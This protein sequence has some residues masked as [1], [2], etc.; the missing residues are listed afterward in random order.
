LAI[1]PSFTNPERTDNMT[2]DLLQLARFARDMALTAPEEVL[3]RQA[4]FNSYMDLHSKVSAAFSHLAPDVPA[5]DKLEQIRARHEAAKQALDDD[6][7]YSSPNGYPPPYFPSRGGEQAHTDRATLLRLLDAARA[8]AA[9]LQAVFDMQRAAQMR[10]IKRWQDATGKDMT[11]PDTTDLCFWLAGQLDAARAELAGVKEAL[12][13]FADY[14]SEWDDP[15]G[16]YGEGWADDELAYDPIVRIEI[17][18]FRRARAA[19]AKDAP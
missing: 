15:E 1:H 6:R 8:N 19:L 18:A 14:A 16:R 17:G 2:D 9:E 11:W 10:A 7:Y 3:R 13:P 4:L 5:A 12:K